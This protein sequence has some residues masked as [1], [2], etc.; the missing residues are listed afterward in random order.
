[1]WWKGYITC[2]GYIVELSPRTT[3]YKLP[4]SADRLFIGRSDS[5][6]MQTSKLASLNSF[7]QILAI[8]GRAMAVLLSLLRLQVISVWLMTLF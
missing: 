6:N 1:M 5:N 8:M 7:P 2:P 3:P 4:S